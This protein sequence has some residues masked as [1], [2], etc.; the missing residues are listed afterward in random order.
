MLIS[1]VYVWV[2]SGREFV[3]NFEIKIY[4]RFRSQRSIDWKKEEG[5]NIIVNEMRTIDTDRL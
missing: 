2:F 4:K 5:I 3:W 1:N